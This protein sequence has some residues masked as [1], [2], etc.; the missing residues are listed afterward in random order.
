[1]PNREEADAP[2]PNASSSPRILFVTGFG[3][4]GSTL[5]DNIVGQFD[6]VTTVGELHYI[7]DR[8]LTDNRLCACRQPFDRCEFWREVMAA[9]DA[10]G[11][12]VD[13]REL[14]RL[15]ESIGPIQA[16]ALR[17][18]GLPASAHPGLAPYVAAMERLYGAIFQVTGCRTIVDSS[19]SPAFGYMIEEMRGFEMAT[20]HVVRDSRAGAFAW[21]KKKLYDDSGPEPMYLSQIQPSRSAQ[22][23]LK[24][25]LVAEA[26]WNRRRG[27]YL[28]LRYE[29]FVVDPERTVAAV[30]KLALGTEPARPAF[31]REK[32]V[33]LGANHAVA[34]N[35]SRFKTG[36]VALRFDDAWRTQFLG[37]DRRLVTFL[38]WALL[39][40]YGYRL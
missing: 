33:D 36:R 34:G 20:L 26:L 35:P 21:T 38:T 39:L 12:P 3:R 32:E 37:V 1:M 23:W 13:A 9:F 15:R 27:N 40:R 25:N 19:K 11:E 10:A 24:W 22:L 18:R 6:G 16:L 28:R 2:A 7:W 31:V 5:L 4:S 30:A 29:D 8:A 14:A 17:V